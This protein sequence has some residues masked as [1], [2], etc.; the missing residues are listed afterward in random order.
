[1]TQSTCY[2]CDE[3]ET[4][5]EHAPP[6]CFFPTE[7]ESGLNLRKNLIT[8]PSCDV[9]N[10][11]K[12]A[13]DE[14]F[15]SIVLAAT[16]HASKVASDHFLGKMIRAAKR[17]PTTYSSF[18]IDRGEIVDGKFRAL[19]IDRERLDRCIEHLAKAIFAYEYKTKWK[20]PII[21][22]SPN[23][24]LG[25][26]E[27]HMESH[28]LTTSLVDLS[29]QLLGA[30]TIYGCNPEV[31]RYRSKHISEPSCFAFC[32]LFYGLFEIYCYSSPTID[33]S[34]T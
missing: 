30:E 21:S 29:R 26:A 10:T 6:K 28:E 18:F 33:E 9:H 25:V 8:V 5:R 32:G 13:D 15:R 17:N 24:H 16:A 12:S 14:Y 1:M 7:A 27:N 2:M 34:A 31:F 19:Q 23:L 3:P 11:E 22:V 20:Y 4:S